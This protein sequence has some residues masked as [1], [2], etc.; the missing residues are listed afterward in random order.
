ML[1]KQ[2]VVAV[3]FDLPS[4]EQKIEPIIYK[5]KIKRTKKKF[6]TAIEIVWSSLLSL[7]YGYT[8]CKRGMHM[9]V[10]EFD[11]LQPIT[12]SRDWSQPAVTFTERFICLTLM[13]SSVWITYRMFTIVSWMVLQIL[14]SLSTLK[15]CHTDCGAKAGMSC[16]FHT[17]MSLICVDFRSSSMTLRSKGKR[18]AHSVGSLQPS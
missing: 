13:W 7:V 5:T 14:H 3:V 18:T 6:G 8:F 1:N 9:P 4:T 11:G 16:E 12:C 17:C 2:V 10:D 15:K